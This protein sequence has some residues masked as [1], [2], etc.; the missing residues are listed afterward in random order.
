MRFGQTAV[1]QFTQS[2]ARNIDACVGN[3]TASAN[4]GK[5]DAGDQKP[6]RG[7]I[8]SR[9]AKAPDEAEATNSRGARAA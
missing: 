6:E 4:H 1:A 9:E 8:T 2:C 7:L 5:S 3:G